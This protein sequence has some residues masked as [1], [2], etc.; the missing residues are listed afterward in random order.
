MR[1]AKV[2]ADQVVY[3][4]RGN[5]HGRPLSLRPP[6]LHPLAMALVLTT[7][8]AEDANR[9]LARLSRTVNQGYL[10][11]PVAQ[12]SSGSSGRTPRIHLNKQ[13]EWQSRPTER[14]AVPGSRSGPSGQRRPK[15]P[16]DGD[17]AALAAGS[18]RGSSLPPGV[19][20]ITQQ[21]SKRAK[22]SAA[23]RASFGGG[24]GASQDATKALRMCSRIV[25]EL[26]QHPHAWPFAKPVDVNQVPGYYDVIKWPADLGTIKRK[27][28]TNMYEDVEAFEDEVKRVWS[29]CY[30]FNKPETDV[31]RIAQTLEAIFNKKM[32]EVPRD[33]EIDGDASEQVKK[34]QKQMLAMQK[35]MLAMQ[36]QSMQQQQMQYAAPPPP[37][38]RQSTGG[39]AR[40]SSLGTGGAR[41]SGG[42]SAAQ[43]NALAML[44]Q[45][46]AQARDEDREM[47]FEEKASLGAGIN[48]LNSNNLAKVVELIKSSMP[49]LGAG[50]DEIE[51][52]INALDNVTLWKLF[53][54]VESCRAVKK[55]PPKK[56][57]ETAQSRTLAIQQEMANAQ[58][59]MLQVEAGLHSLDQGPQGI[60]FSQDDDDDDEVSDSGDED[61]AGLPPPVS[62]GG[63]GSS[64]MWAD[65]QNSKKQR[66]REQQLQAER[67]RRQQQE[68]QLEG[69]RARARAQEQAGAV[70]RERE[71]QR[72]AERAQREGEAPVLDLLGQSNMMSDFTGGGDSGLEFELDEYGGA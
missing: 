45:E 53:N 31:Y 18:S 36:K 4:H 70:A 14:I 38:R 29:N 19:P 57:V 51:V 21:R 41:Q 64:A 1:Q 7:R 68:A 12:L 49:S 27:L 28:D 37:A 13:C 16:A 39:G 40:R 65:F 25:K 54:F 9:E 23:P 55:K 50:S 20:S 43:Q 22:V 6:P 61:D 72:A 69:E 47:T 60:A 24:G 63:A 34:M 56:K 48:K 32:G 11:M 59:E 52:D 26:L 44:Q 10:L 15:P 30:T 5:T 58:Q 2:F 3:A 62:N 46:A 35:Q 17:A 8:Q 71:A 42:G 33:G 67:E 66:E